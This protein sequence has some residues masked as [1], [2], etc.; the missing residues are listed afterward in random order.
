LVY[1]PKDGK[2][3]R[4]LPVFYNPLMKLNRDIS[5][6]LLNTLGRR[7]SV[8]LPLAAT[9][10]RGIRF[11]LELKKTCTVS[12][13][14]HSK[15]AF[16]LMK[17]N[18]RQNKVRGCEV[19]NLDAN[20][21][22]LGSSGFDYIDID[23]Y[24]SPNPFLDSAIK[25]LSRN[26]I[27]AVT[28]TDTA[29]LCGTYEKACQRKYWAVPRRG[30]QMYETGLRILIRKIQLIGAQYDRA[31]F[32]LYSYFR[33]HYFRIFLISKKSKTD[34]DKIIDLHGTYNDAGPMWLGEL[35]DARLAKDMYTQNQLPEN[36][37]LLKIIS[38]ESKVGVV[39]YHDL[40]SIAARHKLR[41]N[42]RKEDLLKILKSKK[43][44]ATETHFMGTGIRSNIEEKAL[45]GI[46]QSRA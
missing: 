41:H 14:D 2:I 20:L 17:K 22:L 34:V 40:H 5:V 35:W 44:R 33:D 15:E 16:C 12:M 4:S 18:L 9:G 43:C 45:I 26:G 11:M 38:E 6:I 3:S 46:I 28:A 7:F 29:P 31:L 27:L 32:P 8:G 39:G 37:R 1:V 23:P 19:H 25:R 36:N 13:N 21:F 24:G 30:P 42:P 10:I